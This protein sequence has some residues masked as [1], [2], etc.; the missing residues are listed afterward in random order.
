M[1]QQE[2]YS[3][4][5]EFNEASNDEREVG[6]V[7][8]VGCGKS[9]L[10]TLTPFALES[11]RTLVVA[12]GIRIYEQLAAEFNPTNPEMFYI[13]RD[14]LDGPPFP[15]PVPLREDRVTVSDL[16]EA[17]VVIA[18][19]DRFR[20]GTDNAW[21]RELPSDFFDLILFDEAHHNVAESWDVLRAAFPEARIVNF[22]ATPQRADGQVM[23]GR[24]I[25]SFSVFRAIQAGYVKRLKGVVLNPATLKFVREDGEEEE[26]PLDEVVRLGEEDAKFRRSIVTSEETLNTIVD[27]SIRALHALR[28]ET[29]E[30]RHKIIAAALNYAHCHQIVAAY[31]TRGLKADF[32]HTRENQK[33][34]RVLS[35]LEAHELDVIVQVRMLG[36]GFDHP[37]LS[38]AAVFSIFASLSP[39][40]QFVG[41]IMRAIEP[42]NPTSPL[43][44]GRVVFHAGANI[45]RRWSDFQHYTE[46]DQAYFD[47]LLPMEGLDFDHATEL[48]IEPD[49]TTWDGPGVEIRE[50]TEV[51]LE[52]LE[53]LRQNPDAVAALELLNKVAAEAGFRLDGRLV[54]IQT[55]KFQEKQARHQGLDERVKTE[56]GR[57]L[58]QHDVNPGGS[59]LDTKHLGRDNFVVMKTAIDRHIRS[60]V[61][62]KR[63]DLSA[64]DLDAIDESFTE[65]LT[66]AEKEV[67]GAGTS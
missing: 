60:L 21:L 20:G 41:R 10:I 36:E 6:I 34:Q 38:V 40:V 42:N 22:S 30:K 52:E 63:A 18:N 54:P 13:A 37:Y 4:L 48:E 19:I 46:A 47:Q 28:T 14:V 24:I 25:Y 8:P 12:P 29:G 26:V 49:G 23:A 55:T 43:N 9:G 44:Q 59:E 53:L 61:D 39:F 45:A 66:A 67:F 17:H 11:R 31:K 27:A 64:A 56:A 32:I 62:K 50:Q 35:K 5:A 15:E 33:T 1:P 2:G 16:E 51:R 7:L 3:S 57:L 65:I 58:A